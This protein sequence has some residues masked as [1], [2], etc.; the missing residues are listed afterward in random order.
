MKSAMAAAEGTVVGPRETT[1]PSAT[2]DVAG[3]I[4]G[5]GRDGDGG[6]DARPIGC[7]LRQ[8]H[9]ELLLLFLGLD[10]VRGFLSHP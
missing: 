8:D 10:T 9:E 2:D 6:P 5:K 7:L 1:I 3:G 4:I